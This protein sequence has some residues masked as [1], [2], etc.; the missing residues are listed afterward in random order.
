MGT[1]PRH[2]AT[3]YLSLTTGFDKGNKGDPALAERDMPIPAEGAAFIWK[4]S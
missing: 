3:S 4:E 2:S 1:R